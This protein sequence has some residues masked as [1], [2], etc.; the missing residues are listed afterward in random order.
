MAEKHQKTG[1]REAGGGVGRHLLHVYAAADPRSLGLFRIGLGLLLLVDLLRRVPGLS[2]WYTNE[3]LLPNH[4]LL[5]RPMARWQFSALFAASGTA[6][7]ALLFVAFGLVFLGLLVGWKTKVFQLL[8]VPAVVSL[9][10]RGIILE[11]GGDVVTNLLT[12]WS[13]FLPLGRRFSVDALLASLKARKEVAPEELEERE[14][15]PEPTA[16]VLSLAVTALFLQVAVIYFFNAVHKSGSIWR[17]GGAIH[18][19]LHQDRIV[20]TLGLWLREHLPGFLSPLFSEA[21]LVVEYAAPFLLLAPVFTVWARRLA[22]VS[23]VG[24]HVGI[25]LLMNVGLFSSAM[26]C[27]YPLFLTAQDWDELGGL[28]GRGDRKRVVFFDAACGVCFQVARVLVRLDAHRNLELVP[29]YEASRLPKG[30]TPELAEQTMIAFDPATG[31]TWTHADAFHQAFRALPLGPLWSWPLRLPGVA[32][33]ARAFYERFA[34]RRRDVSVWLGLAA[35]GLRPPSKGGKAEAAPAVAERP[36]PLSY[37][38]EAAVAVLL[39]AT[40][41]QLLVENRAIPKALKVKQPELLK[42]IVVYPR[43]FQGWSMFAP[44]PPTT[45]GMIVVDAVT[46]DGRRIDPFNFAASGWT[47]PAPET[48]PPRLGQ[49]QFFCDY[50]N[51]IHQKGNAPYRDAFKDW[52]LKHHERTGRPQDRVVSF[53]VHWLEDTSPP[54]GELEARDTKRTKVFE[55]RG[56][57]PLLPGPPAGQPM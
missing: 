1:Q 7:A 11:N 41:S 9:H 23:L 53:E 19:V 42:P 17:D 8:A 44:N 48:I 16:P 52:I 18:Y 15:L 34:A 57:R 26:I 10:S 39:V 35:C 46:A 33:A 20:T 21:T 3:G 56:G 25:A 54:P 30:V 32:Q 27:F 43:M 13:A 22:I 49:D 28:L 14:L 24:L 2:T 29:S 5:W 55:H 40:T 38:R 50:T 12:I 36:R 31:R 6:E 45:D 4:M 47:G 37:L 51:R